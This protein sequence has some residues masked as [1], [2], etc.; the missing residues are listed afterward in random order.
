MR[1]VVWLAVG[2]ILAFYQGVWA[3]ERGGKFTE[4]HLRDLYYYDSEGT[5]VRLDLAP[6]FLVRF[7]NDVTLKERSG[8][9]AKLSPISERKDPLDSSRLL[10]EFDASRKTEEMLEALN[11]ILR[12]GLVEEAWPIFWVENMEAI[13]EEIIVEPKITLTPE[14]L[15]ERM[16][17]YGDF[18]V[19]QVVPRNGAWVFMIAEIKPPLNILVLTNLIQK[20]AWTRRAYP[21]FKFLQDAITASVSV[22]P[23]SGTVGEK[24]IVTLM[25]KVFDPEIKLLEDQLPQFY[26]GLF[27]PIRGYVSSP[28]YPPAYLEELIGGPVKH[29]VR[30]Q[31]RSRIYAF[32][33]EYRIGALGE[34]TIPPQPISYSKN[35][36]TQEITSSEFRLVVNSQIGNLKI[37]DMPVPLPLL[38]PEKKLAPAP[39]VALPPVPSYWFDGWMPRPEL[40][41]R[42][43]RVVGVF[44]VTVGIAILYVMV[45]FW[46]ARGK[47]KVVAREDKIRKVRMLLEEA[48]AARSYE[49][50]GEA[51]SAALAILFPRLSLHPTW[52]EVKE[53]AF[54]RE[55]LGDDLMKALEASFYELGRRYSR[56]FRPTRE[57]LDELE[58]NIRKILEAAET[59]FLSGKE[60]A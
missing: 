41:A 27:R 3:E 49:K 47:R 10:V 38:H 31:G 37:N 43:S 57:S 29:P 13:I 48:R 44:S 23:V 45:L 51:L 11:K 33:W 5:M 25:I 34:W 50:Y 12:S 26:S 6:K 54:I 17:I 42:Y 53:N 60:Y 15:I 35:G 20:D 40:V 22:D 24:R 55:K 46:G 7:R 4:W 1:K 52:D 59:I 16:R 36:I 30:V 39:D 21:R 28:I 58:G 19:R 2:L 14:R 18:S 56:G 8:F 32:S 9:L